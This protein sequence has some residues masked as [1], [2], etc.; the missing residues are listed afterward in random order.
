MKKILFML[1]TVM[2]C[3]AGYAQSAEKLL[4]NQTLPVSFC[5]GILSRL[6]PWR[7]QR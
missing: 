1:V 4:L 7:W 5:V 2:A 3:L 6:L